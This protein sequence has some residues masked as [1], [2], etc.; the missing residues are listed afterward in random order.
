M[1]SGSHPEHLWAEPSPETRRQQQ[2]HWLGE[3]CC[4]ILTGPE[5]HQSNR[6]TGHGR[7]SRP[8]SLPLPVSPLSILY[9]VTSCW[10]F[11]SACLSGWIAKHVGLVSRWAYLNTGRF[12][13]NSMYSLCEISL[14][15]APGQVLTTFGWPSVENCQRSMPKNYIH[16]RQW[17]MWWFVTNAKH[18][19]GSVESSVPFMYSKQDIG[20]EHEVL[21]NCPVMTSM[22]CY[23]AKIKHYWNWA[24]QQ[25]VNFSF[26]HASTLSI[27]DL[28]LT[29]HRAMTDA[30]IALE[31]VE[32]T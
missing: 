5:Q 1:R 10:N 28:I 24:A 27:F 3:T 25:T 9:C 14:T 17:R 19:R 2:Q 21:Q 6:Q 15:L 29:S 7:W 26:I 12:W 13:S 11:C 22:S 31:T 16:S 18:S 20:T 4:F 23:T 32:L 8:V 30:P